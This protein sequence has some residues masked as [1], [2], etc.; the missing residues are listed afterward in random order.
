MIDDTKLCNFP[1]LTE[2][3]LRDLTIGIYKPKQAKSY[4]DE[5]FDEK[6][7]YEIMAHKEIDGVL[8]AQ[9][10]SRHTSNKTY[11]LFVEYTQG[12]KLITGRCRSG[13]YI[14]R[15]SAHVASV[16]WYLGYYHN[17]QKTVKTN[18]ARCTL[19]M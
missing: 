2:D 1:E 16:L 19:I 15:C 8:K 11:N 3:K 18:Q 5:H 6:G 4:T 12:L 13:A 10:R 9:I 14:H 17:K 7:P